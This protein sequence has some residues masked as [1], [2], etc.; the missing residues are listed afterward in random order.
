MN[1]IC[2]PS[3]ETSYNDTARHLESFYDQNEESSGNKK[4]I[5]SFIPDSEELEQSNAI[6][7]NHDISNMLPDSTIKNERAGEILV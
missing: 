5:R 1:F 7:T 3:D 6:R 2:D 4:F